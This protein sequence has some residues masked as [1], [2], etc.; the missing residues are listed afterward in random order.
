M[1]IPF[2]W[3]GGS[4]NLDHW[5]LRPDGE[6]EEAAV[7]DTSMA[8]DLPF[9]F[10]DKGIPYYIERASYPINGWQFCVP[11]SRLEEAK[12]IIRELKFNPTVFE[13][14]IEELWNQFSPE[15]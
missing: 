9:Y 10:E 5:P 2:Q 11:V 6:P 12:E 14:D 8:G 13:E 15:E 7:I 4:G 3:M 1:P